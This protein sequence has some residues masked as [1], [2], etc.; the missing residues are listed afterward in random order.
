MGASLFSMRS[1]DPNPDHHLTPNKLPTDKTG[2]LIPF[3]DSSD[4]L[5]PACTQ[6]PDEA[7]AL[8]SGGVPRVSLQGAAARSR[9]SGGVLVGLADGSARFVSE[10]IEA[11]V[12]RKVLTIK[13]EDPFDDKEF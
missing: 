6:V 9:H 7:P 1:D 2:D 8:T 12:W 3:C 4:P 13:N 5:F 10:Q 11:S